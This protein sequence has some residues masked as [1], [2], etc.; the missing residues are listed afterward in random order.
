M[1]HI[2]C[3]VVGHNLVQIAITYIRFVLLGDSCG[4]FQTIGRRDG[5]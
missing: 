3:F 4:E 5:R 1:Q 2:T